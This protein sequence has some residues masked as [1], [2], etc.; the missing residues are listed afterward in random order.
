M[1]LPR[2]VINFDEAYGW[3]RDA[4]NQGTLGE[5]IPIDLSRM[6]NA[7]IN[8]DDIELA[9][10]TIIDT[11][12]YLNDE[13]K[14]LNTHLA[15]IIKYLTDSVPIFEEEFVD[16][17]GKLDEIL[18]LHKLIK[19]DIKSIMNN[20]KGLG[21]RRIK[22]YY[23]YIP[24]LRGDYNVTHTVPKDI[25]L[26]AITFSQI[27]WK[28][29]DAVSLVINGEE[30]FK[31]IGTKEI[32]EKKAFTRKMLVRANTPV[33]FVLHNRSGNSRQLWVDFEYLQTDNVTAEIPKVYDSSLIHFTDSVIIGKKIAGFENQSIIWKE[34][35]YSDIL[36]EGE[37]PDTRIALPNSHG[38]TFDA[39]AIG[40]G[41]KLE[42]WSGKN[43]TGN[44]IFENPSGTTLILRDFWKQYPYYPEGV[45]RSFEGTKYRNVFTADKIR[46]I[47]ISQWSNG[48]FKIRNR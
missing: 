44:K 23:D 47:N 26:T 38:Y 48:S 14:E 27:G 35:M 5:R 2:Y 16:V 10:Q 20:M 18:E 33:N 41:V 4:V 25:Y 40:D 12:I 3:I 32:A 45:V 30:I 46:Y 24:P 22:G 17:N 29:E 13:F 6:I 42:V 37:Y 15:E 21:K 1:G 36:S 9:V 7:K 31:N 34:D 39:V 8:T 11:N 28:L 43:F 19:E